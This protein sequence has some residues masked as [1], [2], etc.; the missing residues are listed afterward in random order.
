MRDQKLW[1]KCCL[2]KYLHDLSAARKQI[3]RIRAK[4]PQSG[5]DR[6]HRLFLLILD[7]LGDEVVYLYGRSTA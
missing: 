7:V 3:G 5:V 1:C 2:R 4:V 6:R